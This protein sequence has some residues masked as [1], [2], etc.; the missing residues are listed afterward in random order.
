GASA[1]RR[2]SARPRY[3][4]TGASESSGRRWPFGRPK[5]EAMTGWPPCSRTNRIVGSVASMR[6]VS[7][8]RL[9][10]S[11]TFRS[12]R[13]KTRF[14][15]TSRSATERTLAPP[16]GEASADQQRDVPHAHREAPL[17]VVPGEDLAE[18]LVHHPRERAVED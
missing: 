17:V 11:G 14:P 9:S 13:R 6:V 1:A 2:P 4:A 18:R 15:A 3:S 5:C 7:P 10:A 8:I 16:S 12:A